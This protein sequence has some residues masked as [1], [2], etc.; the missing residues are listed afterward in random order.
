[1]QVDGKNGIKGF[2]GVVNGIYNEFIQD[3]KVLKDCC[4]CQKKDV[5]FWNVF[6]CNAMHN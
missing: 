1:M 2:D 4:E 6:E 5:H 3:V